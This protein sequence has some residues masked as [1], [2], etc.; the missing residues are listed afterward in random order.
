VT[1]KKKSTPSKATSRLSITRLR[2]PFLK[3]FADAEP[4]E[5]EQL[6]LLVADGK[7]KHLTDANHELWC[8]IQMADV[9]DAA[10][11]KPLFDLFLLSYGDGTIFK[12]GTT[13]HVASI[14]QHGLDPLT[15][16][17]KDVDRFIAAWLK[18]AKRLKLPIGWINIEE[19]DE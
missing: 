1:A 8:E 2:K 11:G 16:K 4:I 15:W 18:D 3:R 19:E 7:K 9:I 14:A 5:L 6:L 10:S 12:H 13:K 17:K